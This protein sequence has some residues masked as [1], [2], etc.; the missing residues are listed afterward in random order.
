VEREMIA[1]FPTYAP[2]HNL[3]AYQLW[4]A[5]D[6]AGAF[7]EVRRYIELAPDHPNP[8]DSHAEL[9]QFGGQYEAAIE[10]YQAALKAAPGYLEAY[11]GLAEVSQLQGRGDRARAY[12]GQAVAGAPST[13]ARLGS[14]RAVAGSYLYD[15]NLAA[16]RNQLAELAS[17]ANKAGRSEAESRAH[18]DLALIDGAFGDGRG[19]AA[20]LAV[21]GEGA[22]H[23]ELAGIAYALGRQTDSAGAV[24]AELLAST[25]SAS[26]RSGHLVQAILAWKGG[27]MAAARTELAMAPAGA[28]I[29]AVTS[30][31]ERRSGN[32]F[33]ANS[34]R[35]EVANN[36]QLNL[37]DIQDIVARRLASGR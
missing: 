31:V 25:D 19:V 27:D 14:L 28:I 17:Q 20:H 24:A 11:T 26:V 18:R 34:I 8:Y 4:N 3:L 12:L 16:A 35:D 21:G 37:A 22:A 5:G 7:A 23:G 30:Q 6:H 13:D 33:A 32:S 2:F 36:R 10:Q 9:L 29:R 1:A 15:G